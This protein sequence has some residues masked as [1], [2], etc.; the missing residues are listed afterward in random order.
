MWLREIKSTINKKSKGSIDE[1]KTYDGGKYYGKTTYKSV[2][3]DT[4]ILTD[5]AYQR[6]PKYAILFPIIDWTPTKGDK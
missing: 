1:F 2:M 5:T 3:I 6:A 4:N